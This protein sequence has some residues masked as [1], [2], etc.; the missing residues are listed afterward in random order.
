MTLLY[1]DPVFLQH[2]TGSHPECPDRLPPVVRHLNF[3]S[4][5]AF[6]RRPA[7]EIATKQQLQLVHTPEYIHSVE[8]FAAGG[9]GYIEQDTVVCPQSYHV[10][11]MAVGAVCDAVDRVCAGEDTTAFCLVRPPGHHAMPDH[12]MGFCLFNNIAIAARHAQQT[13]GVGQVLIVDFDVHH[14][15]GTQ[16]TFWQDATVGFLSMHRYPF[17]PGTG[18]ED[19]TGAG[20]GLG[21][22][23]NIPVQW[24]TPRSRQL[25]MFRQRLHEFAAR[26]KPELILISAGFDSH[27]DDPIGSLGLESDDFA[28]FTR[29]IIEVARAHTHGRIVSMLEGGYNPLALAEC[30]EQ[31]LHELVG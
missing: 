20:P 19:E 27:K 5:D 29:D 6:C 8:L 24:G 13:A 28:A 4:L 7:W 18:A 30:V 22:T 9:G 26:I 25:D 17:Y 16:A 10:A 15:N 21:A 31:H 11:R 1:Y 14:G 2:Q 12:P 23:C 3:I